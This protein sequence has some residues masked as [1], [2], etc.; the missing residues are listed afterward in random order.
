MDSAEY[1]VE[2]N[3]HLSYLYAFSKQA[4]ELD[5]AGSLNGEFRGLQDSG[6]ATTETAF[7][8]FSELQ[9]LVST[10]QVLSRGELRQILMLYCQL[11]EAG[12]FY[13]TIKNIMGVITL[14]P[15]VL[16][17]FQ[18]LVR[19][20]TTPRAVIGPNAN[21]VFRDLA[22][23]AHDIGFIRLSK[24]LEN[25]FD[26]DI[27]NGISHADY[28][29][30]DDGLRLRKRNGGFPRK[31][32]FEEINDA[33]SRGMNFFQLLVE[34]NRASMQSFDPPKVVTGRFSDNPPMPWT[35]AY[36]AGV[37]FKMSTSSPGA[38]YSP[39][40]LRQLEINGR[41]GGKAM[42]IFTVSQTELVQ[43]LA[44]HIS[45]KGFE[46]HDVA[47]DVQG[48]SD[49]LGEITRLGL[50]DDRIDSANRSDVLLASPWGFRWL[51]SHMDFDSILPPPTIDFE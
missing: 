20:R 44:A 21:R 31:V 5:F 27:R 11:S 13:E 42:A 3:A 30:R 48:L 15:Y 2:L 26:D 50:W 36:T 7:E 6:W 32:S 24:L 43:Q 10:K 41:L 51:H 38:V 45:H 1:S 34:H 17:P 23:M 29:M 19:V 28:V 33:L 46:P 25:A 14:K 4:N 12:G 18:G 49:L 47:L 16:W 37:G 39:E 9:E 40:Y 35:V 8:V 22:Q